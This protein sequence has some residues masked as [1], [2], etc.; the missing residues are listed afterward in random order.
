VLLSFEGEV[1]V[2]DFGIAKARGAL[3]SPDD[4]S[5]HKLQGKFGYMSPEQARGERVDARSDLFSLGTILYEC[6]TGMN[7]FAAPRELET[8]RRVQACEYPPVEL[9]RADCPPELVALLKVA[10]APG[11]GHRYPDAGRMYEA[12]LAFLYGQGSRYG[13]RDLSEFLSRFRDTGETG[14]TGVGGM[15][16]PM[17]EA[18]G[19]NPR[20]ERTP[21]EVPSR[22]SPSVR[23][24]SS[25]EIDRAA[26]MGERREVTALM[27]DLPRQTPAAVLDRANAI[28]A[29]WG[30][31]LLPREGAQVAAIFGL[32]DPDGR[33]TET[34]T[35]CALVALRSLDAPRPA[36]AG[37]HTSRIHVSSAGEAIEDARL[38]IL[39]DT[40]GELARVREGQAAMSA[41]AKRQVQELFEFEATTESDRAATQVPAVVV[42]DVR[43]PGEAFGRFVGRKDELRRIG[44]LLAVATRRSA[45]VLTVRGDHGV[46]KTRLLYEVEKR[47]RRGNYNMGFHIASCPP[48]GN[49]FPLSGIACMLHVLCGT[50]EG[51]PSDRILAVQPRLRALGLQGDEVNVVLTWLGASLPA[52]S[53]GNAKTLLRQAFTRMVQSLC[54]DRPH[55]FCWDVAHAMD[56]DSFSLLEVV[57]QRLHHT[58][59]RSSR[60]IP[61]STWATWPRPMSRGSSRSA[62]ASTPCPM[63]SCG[64]FGRVR[65]AIPCSWRRSSRPL[66]MQMRLR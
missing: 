17:L 53:G 2:T 5:G 37:I 9:A 18:E 3:T 43:G 52:A 31:R 54:E 22:Q 41:Q 10:M 30:G 14:E 59:W 56:E 65:A 28:V 63:S 36:G 34:A 49:D 23:L 45:L 55:T 20:T 33:D 26:E 38:R 60:E 44:E 7:P 58:R 21:V 64:S 62:S 25:V 8:L 47:L 24:A 11:A 48:R 15:P 35:R 66:S 16:G 39:L 46:G 13:A 42:K 4:T 57:F 29:R 50:V 61:L 51:D 40:A 27:I 6:V 19:R 12:L 1:K 32:G